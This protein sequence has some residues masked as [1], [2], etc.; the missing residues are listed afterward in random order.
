[1]AETKQKIISIKSVNKK[2]GTIDNF[3]CEINEI[4]NIHWLEIQ[5]MSI[6]MSHYVIDSLNN[7]IDFN[8]GGDKQAILK[9]GFYTQSDITTE[10]KTKM[11]AASVLTFTVTVDNIT[12]KMTISAGSNF[13]LKFDQ[14]NSAAKTLGY[15]EVELTGANTYTAPNL[16][17][18]TR[19]YT[20]FNVYSDQLTKS[21]K[22][23]YSSNNKGSLIAVLNNT[24][25]QPKTHFL[26]TQDDHGKVL[27][28]HNSEEKLRFID[29]R[30]TD[31][32][33]NPIEFNGVDEIVINF[34]AYV[35]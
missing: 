31:L 12:Q 29:I 23:V 11:D 16:L 18:L 25:A 35:R 5:N 34:I 17:N 13:T 20:L 27:I 3:I 4:R 30:I 21:H 32:D 8:D 14:A 26:Y 28:H 6:P 33:N 19:R 10:I 22:M 2:S 7:K 9:N 15:N 1:M 24:I